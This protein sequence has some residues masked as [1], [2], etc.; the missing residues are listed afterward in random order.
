VTFLAGLT[1]TH[2]DVRVLVAAGKGVALDGLSVR[3]LVYT[4]ALHTEHGA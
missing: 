3:G 2:T 4:V 1:A